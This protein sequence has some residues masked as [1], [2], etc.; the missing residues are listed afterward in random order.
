MPS[1]SDASWSAYRWSGTDD[2]PTFRAT[3]GASARPVARAARLELWINR[4]G[5]TEGNLALDISGHLPPA[6]E[7]DWPETTRLSGLYADGVFRPLPVPANGTCLVALPEAASHRMLWLSW[8]DSRGTLPTFSGPLSAHI[9]WPREIPVEN[10]RVNVYPPRHYRVDVD[11]PS[12]AAAE[13]VADALV[14]DVLSSNDKNHSSHSGGVSLIAAPAPD[15][16]KAFAPGAS[17]RLVNLLPVEIGQALAVALVAALICW[18]IVPVWT[19]LVGNETISWL[20]LAVFWW[21]C[22]TP[23][24]VGPA[25][26]LWACTSAVRRRRSAIIADPRASTAH[27][28]PV[29]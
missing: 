1:A 21:L 17:L 12:V 4:D 13:D 22:L 6:V 2:L 20:A 11:A 23:S 27:A 7:F 26:A 8:V 9:P 18:R 29:T 28:P 16:G 3:R 19:W 15:P 14:P 5:T 24:W 10:L 25:L